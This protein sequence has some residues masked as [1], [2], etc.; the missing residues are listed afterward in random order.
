[1]SETYA[2]AG[3]FFSALI[4][5]TETLRQA[6]VAMGGDDRSRCI[7][8]LVQDSTMVFG[9]WEDEREAEG[10]GFQIIKGENV[11]VPL[12]AFEMPDGVTIA[13]IPCVGREQAEAAGDAWA[14]YEL[15][16]EAASE[17]RPDP[18]LKAARPAAARRRSVAPVPPQRFAPVGGG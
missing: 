1:M 5:K 4:E 15:R 6:L 3:S 10:F 17:D 8:R 11:I 14:R 18:A 2:D 16:R 12:S 13:A 7:T 9:V